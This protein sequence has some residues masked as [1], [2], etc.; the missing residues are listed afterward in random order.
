MGTGK[1]SAPHHKS[2]IARLL[3]PST[4]YRVWPERL[5]KRS[6]TVEPYFGYADV[7]VVAFLAFLVI[8]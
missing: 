3:T 4:N 8:H 5:Y 6:Y 1:V 2:K 7:T